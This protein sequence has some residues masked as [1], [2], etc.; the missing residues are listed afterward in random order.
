[1]AWMARIKY[2]KTAKFYKAV[3]FLLY[4]IFY[5]AKENWEWNSIHHLEEGEGLSLQSPKNPRLAE[6]LRE[7]R[8]LK[9]QNIVSAKIIR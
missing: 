4:L 3:C 2:P 6:R 5:K 8:D 1:M 9:L 7:E